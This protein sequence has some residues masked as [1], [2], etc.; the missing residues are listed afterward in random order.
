M[1]SQGAIVGV[2]FGP[3]GFEWNGEMVEQVVEKDEKDEI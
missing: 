3:D 1:M 2:N